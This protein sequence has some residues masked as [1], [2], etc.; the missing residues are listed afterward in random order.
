[1]SEEIKVLSIDINEHKSQFMPIEFFIATDKLL[2]L[3]VPVQVLVEII[4][5]K[6]LVQSVS[7]ADWQDNITGCKLGEPDELTFVNG[8]GSCAYAATINSVKVRVKPGTAEFN[9]A[10]SESLDEIINSPRNLTPRQYLDRHKEI[11]RF[12]GL[13]LS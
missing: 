13:D 2:P 6:L 4:P 8:P 5:T 10:E 12:T 11:N 1:V 3:D 9:Q 7:K